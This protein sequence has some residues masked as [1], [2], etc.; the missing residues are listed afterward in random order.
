MI[1]EYLGF[2]LTEH[3][4]DKM[5]QGIVFGALGACA[6][7]LPWFLAAFALPYVLEGGNTLAAAVA[8]AALGIVGFL[9]GLMAKVKA[10][11]ANFDATYAMV[12]HARIGL[13]NHLA[14][15]P[16]GR[17][18]LQRDGAWAELITAQ[19]SMYQDIVTLVWGCVVA[20]TAFPVLLWL[21]LLWLNWASAVVLLLALPC[22]MLSVPLAYRLLDRAAAKVAKARQDASVNVLEVITGARDLRFFDPLEQR[23][24]TALQSLRDYRDQSMKTEVAPAPAL[25]LFS[26]VIFI[27]AAVSIGVASLQC[28][29]QGGSPA[30]FFVVILLTLRLGMAINEF[31]PYLAEMRFVG[32]IIQRIRDVM[33]EP[34]M[35]QTHQGQQPQDGGIDVSH[36]TFSYGGA[37]VIHNASLQVGNGKMAAL[38][39][40]SGSGKSTLAA[41]TARLWDVKG[42]AIRI[43][44]VDLRD[45]DERTLQETVSMVLQD[46]VLFP[47]TVADNI[48]L[49]CP[50]ASMDKVIEVAKAACIHERVLQLPQGYET[51]LES[52]DVALSGGERQRL[53]IARAILKDAPVLILD[54]ATA[55]LDLENETAVQQALANLCREKTTLVI[56]HR[57]W[58]IQDADCIFVMDKGAIVERGTHVELM[59]SAGLYAKMWEVQNEGG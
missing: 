4:D 15:L 55:S 38:V 56:A 37:D 13:A 26:L 35:P 45:M 19:F 11:C 23:A 50:E 10:L 16:L 44:N 41:L 54:E 53:A 52:G 18:L 32:T 7:A 59:N 22:A 8:V 34:I 2:D 3:R 25:L 46:V 20:G 12:S 9:L 57:L 28:A 40:P 27:G 17:V 36:V 33:D 42:G 30:T 29:A 43:G 14:K 31:G 58:T 21:L 6:E 39:G 1:R 5:M 51:L 47:M 49:G 48:R 24:E